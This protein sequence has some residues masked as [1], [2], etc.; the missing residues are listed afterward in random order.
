MSRCADVY[1]ELLQQALSQFSCQMRP[2]FR[3]E[4]DLIIAEP[5]AEEAGT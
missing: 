1:R 4:T 5:E 2:E 3:L